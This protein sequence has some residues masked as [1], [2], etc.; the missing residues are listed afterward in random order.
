MMLPTRTHIK[1]SH[2]LRTAAN[3]NRADQTQRETPARAVRDA[4]FAHTFDPLSISPTFEI[5]GKSTKSSPQVTSPLEV[6]F[7]QHDPLH[8]LP[9]KDASETG[10]PAGLTSAFRPPS[11]PLQVSSQLSTSLLLHQHPLPPVRPLSPH[12]TMAGAPL[13]PPGTSLHLRDSTISCVCP[14]GKHRLAKDL[15]MVVTKKKG[16]QWVHRTCKPWSAKEKVA[17]PAV[18][19]PPDHPFPAFAGLIGPYPTARQVELTKNFTSKFVCDGCVSDGTLSLKDYE[20]CKKCCGW[21]HKFC[22]L[23]GEKGDC[24]GPVCNLC[25]MDFLVNHDEIRQWQRR[26]LMEAVQEAFMFLTDV[27]TNHEVWRREWCQ[28]FLT[29]FYRQVIPHFSLRLLEFSLTFITQ[30]KGFFINFV[31]ERRRVQQIATT[32]G[33]Y[34]PN[35]FPIDNHPVGAPRPLAGPEPA[36][37]DGPHD[38]DTIV[39]DDE[40]S[41]DSK[42]EKIYENIIVA[43][44]FTMVATKQ[45][46]YMSPEPKQ[47]TRSPARADGSK[48]SH[49]KKKLNSEATDSAA[50]QL[51]FKGPRKSIDMA[52]AMKKPWQVY[53]YVSCYCSEKAD[54]DDD[55]FTCYKCGGLQHNDCATSDPDDAKPL[56]N[57]CDDA[58]T[59][60]EDASDLEEETEVKPKTASAPKKPTASTIN[61]LDAPKTADGKFNFLAAPTTSAKPTNQPPTAK[62][63]AQSRNQ[64]PPPKTKPQSHSQMLP[65]PPPKAK[66][67][68]HNQ[69]KAPSAA[70]AQ[71]LDE[72]M[73]DEIHRLSSTI[74]WREYLTLPNEDDSNITAGSKK[75]PQ[76]WLDECDSRLS[77]MLTAAGPDEIKKY[78]EPVL[79][80]FPRQS[81]QI[82]K[83]LTEM[84]HWMVRKGPWRGKRAELGLLGEVFGF[85]DKG[86]YWQGDGFLMGNL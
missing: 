71:P 51:S 38:G 34:G 62:A 65:P 55:H 67:Q 1:S 14:P 35:F 59:D 17:S 26:R 78:L 66:T 22:I 8:M 75:P 24:G 84:A 13:S 83:N 46:R 12:I 45:P 54:M 9:S 30:N 10:S 61:F 50:S 73:L 15:A 86:S 48:R 25:Y 21:Q 40:S 28:K 64:M 3:N 85:E 33:V 2:L 76:D 11:P 53:G 5:E 74:L 80:A 81:E 57:R 19:I 7:V 79:A 37:S 16:V 49:K 32:T 41:V 6:K 18:E 31:L 63:K 47:R 82:L 68:S 36:E 44:P 72:D 42:G 69:S 23:Y 20:Q 58:D 70:A 29:R 39:G 27:E 60:M 56:C 43:N 52:K 4:F 77:S